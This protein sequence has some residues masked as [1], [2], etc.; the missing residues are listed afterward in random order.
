MNKIKA[1]NSDAVAYLKSLIS[2]TLKIVDM[3]VEGKWL[4]AEL[5][6]GVRFSVKNQS[7]D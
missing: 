3:Y 5:N 7:V 6:S 2:P 1:I 4:R